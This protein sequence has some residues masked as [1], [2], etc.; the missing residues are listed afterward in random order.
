VLEHE[1][2]AAAHQKRMQAADRTVLLG[3]RKTPTDI[4]RRWRRKRARRCDQGGGE[5]GQDA[6]ASRCCRR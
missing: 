6:A 2:A 1:L 3:L 4:R 5:A